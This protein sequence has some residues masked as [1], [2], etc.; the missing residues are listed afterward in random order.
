MVARLDRGAPPAL[1][2]PSS[3]DRLAPLPQELHVSAR[4]PHPR[5]ATPPSPFSVSFVNVPN[6]AEATAAQ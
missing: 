3:P 4:R 5:S 1:G 6:A 2:A